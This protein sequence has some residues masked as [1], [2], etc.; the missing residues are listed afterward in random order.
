MASRIFDMRQR[1]TRRPVT[2]FS[3]CI[4]EVLL[5]LDHEIDCCCVKDRWAVLAMD[6]MSRWR[7]SLDVTRN[8][9]GSKW[10]MYFYMIYLLFAVWRRI[11]ETICLFCY[12]TRCFRLVFV[13]GKTQ[14][15][16]THC[17]HSRIKNFEVQIDNKNILQYNTRLVVNQWY[18]NVLIHVNRRVRNHENRWVINCWLR[19]QMIGAK[20][21]ID[22]RINIYM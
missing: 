10:S 17:W 21:E 9:F 12:V 19:L 15:C 7:S 4:K 5:R 14:L 11:S 3:W 6:I 16:L 20:Y 18:W 13:K 22:L 8:G 2:C 1:R